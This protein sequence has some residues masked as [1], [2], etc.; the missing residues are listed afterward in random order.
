V[1]RDNLVQRVRLL[2]FSLATGFTLVT[3]QVVAIS[4]GLTVEQAAIKYEGQLLGLPASVLPRGELRPALPPRPIAS[5]FAATLGS[6]GG[7]GA[8]GPASGPARLFTHSCLKRTPSLP[9]T[10]QLPFSD[11]E[12]LPVFDQILLGVGPDGHVASL[13]PNRPE[14]A[15]TGRWVLPVS[16]S[17]KPPPERITYSLPVRPACASGSAVPAVRGALQLGGRRRHL[18]AATLLPN[19]P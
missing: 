13:F 1:K 2:T 6:G 9:A 14:V 12:G 3:T 4:E 15:A 19:N 10:A 18:W 5:A 11:A 16:A 17:P 7:L 8:R